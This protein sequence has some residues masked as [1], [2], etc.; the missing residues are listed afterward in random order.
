MIPDFDVNSNDVAM[1]MRF[2]TYVTTW[3]RSLKYVN[4]VGA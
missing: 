4:I 3:G 2:G 1:V